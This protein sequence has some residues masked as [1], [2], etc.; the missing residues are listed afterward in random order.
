MIEAGFDTETTGL[1]VGDHRI[2]EIYI[3]LW[4]D[5]V[6][7]RK[8]HTFIDPRRSITAEA[9]A[10][11]KI[12][13]ADLVGKPEWKE[14]APTIQAYLAKAD[15]HV[16]HNAPFDIGFLEYELKRVGL[17]FPK[18]PV[19]DTGT[20]V[21]ATPDG[22]KPTL[23]ELCFACGVDYAVTSSMGTGAHAA[24][25]DVDVMMQSLAAA[26]RF[27]FVAEPEQAHE[28]IQQAA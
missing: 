13:A 21:W 6:L 9:Q 7:L 19:I 18:R 27:G 1:E 8:F 4:R 14:V 20:F 25:Y 23:Q 22:K 11:H 2:I 12:T 24:D 15:R 17:Q 26:R 28:Q 16:A 5:G 10:V 3:G